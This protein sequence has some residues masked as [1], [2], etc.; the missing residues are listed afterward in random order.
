MFLRI[1]GIVVSRTGM[2]REGER[3]KVISCGLLTRIDVIATFIA[4]NE[5]TALGQ[6]SFLGVDV[7]Y[8]SG[9]GLV[10]TLYKPQVS[11]IGDTIPD[12]ATACKIVLSDFRGSTGAAP[13]STFMTPM[14]ELT[15]VSHLAI[16][17]QLTVSLAC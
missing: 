11:A 3:D 1:V 12:E 10:D 2:S 4:L 8:T 17:M 7:D 13:T 15:S 9:Q 16:R 5:A 14:Q 6:R